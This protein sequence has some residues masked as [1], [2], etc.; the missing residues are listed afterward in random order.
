MDGW[1]DRPGRTS[2]AGGVAHPRIPPLCQHTTN[3]WVTETVGEQWIAVGGARGWYRRMAQED[4]RHGRTGGAG[5][6]EAREEKTRSEEKIYLQPGL[7]SSEV[8]LLGTFFAYKKMGL[9]GI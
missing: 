5:G 4:Q 7:P 8:G 6:L 9:I 2:T 3:W 1:A